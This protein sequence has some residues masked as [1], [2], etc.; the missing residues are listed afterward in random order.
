ME[1]I[2]QSFETR[3]EMMSY[4]V[5]PKSKILEVGVFR[6][7]FARFLRSLEPT[8]LHLVDPFEGNLCSG[9]ADG[10]NI[11][12]IDGEQAFQ[13]VQKLF[14]DDMQVHIHRGWSPQALEMFPD[15]YFDLVYL[16]GDHT[17]KGISKDLEMA[18]RVV[19]DGGYICGHDYDRNPRKCPY[20]YTFRDR[21]GLR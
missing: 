21:R 6:G 2:M 7:K 3:E 5:K 20:A 13:E 8:E 1:D 19:R 15:E 18:Y 14:R 17:Y 16:D 11:E 12:C 4:L 9:D 10:I